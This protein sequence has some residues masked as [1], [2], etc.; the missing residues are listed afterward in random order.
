MTKINT[1]SNNKSIGADLVWTWI[2]WFL[3]SHNYVTASSLDYRMVKRFI[4]TFWLLLFCICIAQ[5]LCC[6]WQPNSTDF[7]FNFFFFFSSAPL[8]TIWYHCR[9]RADPGWWHVAFWSEA[10]AVELCPWGCW[11]GNWENRQVVFSFPLP[12]SLWNEA[13]CLIWKTG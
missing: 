6:V 13:F 11:S 7:I 5:L 2:I 3:F 8:H 9:K 10:T 1:C 4:C 12:N